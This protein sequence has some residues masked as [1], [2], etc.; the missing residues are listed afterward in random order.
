M[1]TS[2]AELVDQLDHVWTSIAALGDELGEAE[3]KAPTECPGWT[4]QDNLAHIV[5]IESTI[6]GRPDPEHES[7]GGP[8]VKNDVGA[9]NE[10][11]VEA[12]RSASGPEVLAAFRE[13]SAERLAL[14][15]APG[16][17]LGAQTWTPVGPGAVR[18]LLPFR[19]FDSWVH[20]QDMRR[21]VSRPGDFD[22]DVA[23]TGLGR[24]ESMMPKVV[25]KLV[26]PPDRTVVV[27][28]V[29]GPAGRTF[30]LGMKGGRA[31][32]LEVIPAAPTV[33]LG[34]DG[35]T[36]LRLGAGRGD[37]A[38]ILDSG[39]VTF[40]GDATLGRAVAERMNFLF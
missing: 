5:A 8:H 23:R 1:T 22:S 17:D 27:F 32:H 15:R 24:V 21:A 20:E 19:V 3:W 26:R 28:D 10:V 9:R 39:A 31:T 30:A 13:V 38:A 40:A 34:M 16:Y 33:T 37:A 6:L 18:D 2:D 12:Y 14:L 35:E 4:V 25:G 36:F 29:R 7:P 11:W